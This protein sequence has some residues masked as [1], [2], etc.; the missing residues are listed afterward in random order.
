MEAYEKS[1]LEPSTVLVPLQDQQYSR[2][3]VSRVVNFYKVLFGQL[4]YFH[5]ELLDGDAIS[6][7]TAETSI[8]N[9]KA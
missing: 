5:D 9:D 1:A 2:V 6:F 4:P 8:L 7:R 3:Q